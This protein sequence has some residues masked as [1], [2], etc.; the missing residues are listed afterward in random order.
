MRTAPRLASANVRIQAIAVNHGTTDYAELLIRSFVRHHPDRSGLRLLLLDNDSPGFERLEEL[1]VDGVQL[2]RSGYGLEHQ[3]VTHGEIVAA[4]I[5]EHPDAEAYLLLDSDVCFR[6]DDTIGGL[7]AELAS[8]PTVFGVQAQWLGADGSVFRPEPSSGFP[9]TRI[10]ES[11]RPA[12]AGGWSEPYE[13]EVE[14]RAADRI[15]PFCALLRNTEALRRTV[16]LFGLSAGLV[17]SER[18][19][20]WWDTLGILTQ[21]MATHGLG[22][23]ESL[24]GVVHFG[25]VSRDDQ[26]AAEKAAARDRLLADYG[27]G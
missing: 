7:A 16:E 23:K 17:Q 13:F 19:G 11:V 26:W 22:W 25:N 20:R 9:R 3:V 5:L 6:T 18:T 10:R 14:N 12:G 2:R 1:A 4:A 8:D 15:H 27:R 24:Y 21:V